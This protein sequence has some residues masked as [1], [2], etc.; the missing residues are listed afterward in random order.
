M[1]YYITNQILVCM[2]ETASTFFSAERYWNLMCVKAG[3]VTFHK[4]VVMNGRSTFNAISVI[5]GN[6]VL[7]PIQKSVKGFFE[8]VVLSLS[9]SKAQQ[10]P[11]EL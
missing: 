4:Y 3:K 7:L 2:F 10:I 6:S 11:L 9:H 1:F 5:V 8:I